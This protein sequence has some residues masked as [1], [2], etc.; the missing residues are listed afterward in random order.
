MCPSC[1]SRAREWRELSGLGR[2]WSFIVPHPPL[3]PVFNPLSPYNVIVVELEEAP[4]IRLVG[5]LVGE[6]QGAINGVDPGTIRIGEPVQAV[7][8]PM[9]DDVTLIRWVRRC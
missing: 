3:F 6:P 4:S 9:T 5:N 8:V 7:F 1:H 2:I